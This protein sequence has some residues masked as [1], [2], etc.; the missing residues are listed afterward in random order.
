M[1]GASENTEVITHL[2]AICRYG[3]YNAPAPPRRLQDIPAEIRA[4]G[5]WRH[6][7]PHRAGIHPHAFAGLVAGTEGNFLQ[8]PFQHGR[9]A[10]GADVV[11][12]SHP[13]LDDSW[14]KAKLAN[15]EQA[16][17]VSPWVATP[18]AVQRYYA[19]SVEAVLA[20]QANEALKAA[21]AQ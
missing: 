14:D 21:K 18:D 5:Q 17:A 20:I 8:Q 19:S 1:R 6:L 10:A 4:G 13:F 9:Q 7:F 11:L 15:S 3:C 2:T 16:G 12:S